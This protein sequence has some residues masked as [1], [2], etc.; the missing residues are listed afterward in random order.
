MSVGAVADLFDLTVRTLHHYDEIGLVVPGERSPAGY[1]V[2]THDDLV[3]LSTVVVYRRLGFSLDEVAQLLADPA[4]VRDHLT[5]QRAAVMHRLDE[6]RELV[7][8][9]DHALEKDMSNEQMTTADMRELFGDGFKE[10]Y[11]AE[12]QERWGD[13]PQWAQSAKRTAAYTKADWEAIKAEGDAINAAFVAALTSGQPAT[14]E[15]AMDAAEAH[16]RHIA[17]R[18]YDLDH[19]FH[20]NLAEMY[21]GDERFT[22]T[23][24]DI[25][26]GLAQYVRDAVHA[27]ADR[28]A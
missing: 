26:A 4:S 25:A 14:S 7:T 5:R 20:R 11:Q 10:E 22:K 15:A 13:T 12:A 2:Y 17:D 24:E 21:V 9:I 28:H 16:R 6:L 3:R 23:Y 19:D 1:R 27:N 18:F 8:A